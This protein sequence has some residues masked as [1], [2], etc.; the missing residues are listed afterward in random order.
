M[1]LKQELEKLTHV[2]YE[3]WS[4][5]VTT[6]ALTEGIDL[7]EPGDKDGKLA[8][9][10]AIAVADEVIPSIS[11]LRTGKEKWRKLK[12]TYG[13]STENQTYRETLQY[14]PIM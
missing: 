4:F 8:F 3:K 12:D 6:W 1:S 7:A 5:I 14:K 9:F 13:V 2:N 10:L 11:S